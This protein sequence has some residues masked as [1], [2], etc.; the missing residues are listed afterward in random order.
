MRFFAPVARITTLR[1]ILA[2]ANQF[3]YNVN[4]MDVNT[5]F[6]NGDLEED[7]YMQIPEGIEHDG[8]KVWKLKKSLYGLEQ[9]ARCWFKNFYTVLRKIGF[10]ES[11]HDRCLN[12]KRN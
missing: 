10:E 11:L 7:I 4:D 6:L 2:L 5:A 9:A 3:D 12:S 1:F 8:T